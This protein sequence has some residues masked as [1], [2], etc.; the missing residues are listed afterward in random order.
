[1][2][3]LTIDGCCVEAPEGSTILAAATAAGFEIPTLCHLKEINAIG[4]CR[5]CVVEVD[6]MDKLPPA[7]NTPAQDGMVSHTMR[8]RLVNARRRVYEL[9][10]SNHD[11]H[12]FSCTKNG[13]CQLQ[14]YCNEYKVAYSSYIGTHASLV[15]P[16]KGDH[17]YLIYKPD[18]CIHC[19][20]CV[21][22]CAKVTGRSSI[23]C[24][25]T[26][27]FNVIDAPFGTDW[28][29]TTC[30]SC[31]N[32][33]Q[34]C[35]TGALTEKRRKKYR[36]WEIHYVRTTCPHCAVGCQYDMIVKDNQ[37]VDAIAVDGPSNHVRACVKGRSGSFD[38]IHSPER[39]RQPLIKNHETGAFEPA[40]WDEALSLA[41]AKFKQLQRDYGPDSLAGFACPRSPNEDVYMVQKL[42]RAC[43]GT[44]NVDNCAWER[45]APSVRGLAASLGYGS[46]TNTIYDITHNVDCILV[47]D[48]DPEEMHPVMGMQIRRAAQTG[49][50][51]IVIGSENV[52]MIRDADI[53]LAIKPGTNIALINAMMHVLI[54]ENLVDEA[55]IAE[56]T[57]GYAALRAL[58][59]D[60]T[61]EYAAQVCGVDKDYIIEAARMY[62]A[63]ERAPITYS[64]G[65]KDYPCGA[66]GAMALANLA[67]LAGKLGKPGCGVN[68]MR[69][70]NNVQG[71]CDMGAIPDYYPGYQPT[72]QPGVTEKFETIW[73]VP[74][75]R[76]K[77]L[78][79]A[80]IFSAAIDGSV[81][82][83]Y[84]YGENPVLT[85]ADH[86]R[87]IR[88]LENLDFLVVQELF[89]TETAQYADIILPGMS[90]GE[91]EGTFSNTERRVQRVRKAV[92]L[93][94][95][96][97][98]DLRADTDT[99]IDLMNRMGYPQP[100]LSPAEIM[101]E[102]AAVAPIF[103]GISHARLDNE[104]EGRGI[105][106]PCPNSGHPGTPI[107]HTN[108]F[109][110]GKGR[111]F[112]VTYTPEP[113]LTST[114]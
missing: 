24:K 93:N 80:E 60:Y 58:L 41:A 85:E 53:S 76:K 56:R 77:G 45:H 54:A 21:A 40:S 23:V 29:K 73:G 65:E 87:V 100:R 18:L 5:L 110:R 26:G 27:M 95:D 14:R 6:G 70:K 114:V 16:E 88:A 10:L 63:A 42:V 81:K 72:D 38:F 111:L 112:P 39:L 64:V 32:C 97:E 4:S 30:E 89:M 68:P 43:F 106:W 61:P 37:I 44:N 9:L 86:E 69:G 35:P 31:G 33:A 75:S 11:Q 99:I 7:C 22:T 48:S 46:M 47:I 17:P 34:A 59:E 83:L 49:T 8:R 78:N 104:M 79:A 20:R 15:A 105:Q 25:K 90:Y 28:Q 82:G 98:Y 96:P 92:D 67:M 62:A 50:H 102:F 101:D 19:M 74:L 2:L 109:A 91:K 71:V 66:E 51:L 3:H 107:L 57:E 1:M 13:A 113:T 84:I 94:Y 103:A 12:C 108:S 55:F 52:E 36:D